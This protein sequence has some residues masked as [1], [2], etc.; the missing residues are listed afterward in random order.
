MLAAIDAEHG[1]LRLTDG[2][3][4]DGPALERLCIA[5]GI[6]QR[7]STLVDRIECQQVG[8]GRT[9]YANA[10]DTAQASS[11]ATGAP[12]VQKIIVFLSDGAANY[13]PSTGPAI[14]RNQPC[15]AGVNSAAAAK[16][17]GTTIYG[18]GYDLDGNNGVY[19]ACQT[20]TNQNEVPGMNAL[21]AMQRISSAPDTFYNKPDPGQ[22]NSIFTKI[23]ADIFRTAQ[24]IDDNLT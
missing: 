21:Q 9:G 12:G 3:L 19:Q 10:L 24:L 17:Q 11:R 14:Y 2:E 13:G 23:A 15:Q 1:E 7:D 8:G 6:A 18:I 20:R 5:P 22:L 4:S 16:A